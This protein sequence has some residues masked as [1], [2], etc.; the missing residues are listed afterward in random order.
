MQTICALRDVT[1]WPG[2]CF[3]TRNWSTVVTKVTGILLFGGDGN[4]SLRGKGSTDR[5]NSGEGQD[6]LPDLAPG[7]LDDPNLTLPLSL[8]QALVAL[9]GV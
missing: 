2:P 6:T 4:D 1:A 8:V 9:N 7:E 5:F 3:A